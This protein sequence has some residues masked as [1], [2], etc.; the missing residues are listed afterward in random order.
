MPCSLSTRSSGT[1]RCGVGHR[2]QALSCRRHGLADAVD[3]SVFCVDVGWR[4]P[5]PQIFRH[6]LSLLDVDARDSVFVG[7]DPRQDVAG[8]ERSGLRAILIDPREAPG[9]APGSSV[10]G[11]EELSALLDSMMAE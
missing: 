7:D 2:H 3:A 4:K 6:V 10:Q 11:L 8:A 9:V 5:A 1:L